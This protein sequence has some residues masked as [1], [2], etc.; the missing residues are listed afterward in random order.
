MRRILGGNKL[1]LDNSPNHFTLYSDKII[2][3]HSSRLLRKY[4]KIVIHITRPNWTKYNIYT[5]YY[6]DQKLVRIRH[7]LFTCFDD[8]IK[9]T[10]SLK[11]KSY[12][13]E[14]IEEYYQKHFVTEPKNLR[15]I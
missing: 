10:T 14:Q 1:S 8:T 13:R 5:N 6:P 15:V 7:C 3:G 12:I 11:A 9:D 2:T 4:I